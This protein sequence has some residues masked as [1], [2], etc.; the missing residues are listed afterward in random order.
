MLDGID[1]ILGYKVALRKSNVFKPI[2]MYADQRTT[3]RLGKTTYRLD[4]Q[5]PF[6][7]FSDISFAA[8]FLTYDITLNRG[9]QVVLLEVNYTLS[10]DTY[11]WFHIKGHEWDSKRF[12]LPYGTLLADSVNVIK[13][14]ERGKEWTKR[15]GLTF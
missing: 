14:L 10:N 4:S 13:I 2:C 8:R 5:G 7:V 9:S 15:E 1:E 12:N 6:A 3:Y 11:L